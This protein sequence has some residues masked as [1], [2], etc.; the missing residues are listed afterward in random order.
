MR[1]IRIAAGELLE[2]EQSDIKPRGYA[3]EA[4]ITAENVWQNFT[5]APGTITGYYPALGP[6]VRVDSHAYKDYTIPPFFDSLVAKLIVKATDYDLAVNKLERAL[7]EFTIEGVRTIIPFLLA[8]SKSREFRR[9]FF[10]TSYVEKNLKTILENTHDDTNTDPAAD[11]E[12][13][14]TEAIKRYRKKR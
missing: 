8:I 13:V 1:Q 4:R 5:P 3:I 2:I 9:G 6:S 10:D 12:E 11:L 7:E 14:I